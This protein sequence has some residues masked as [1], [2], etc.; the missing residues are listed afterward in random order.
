MPVI[1][2]GINIKN[3]A[4]KFY[5]RSQGL[6][7][8]FDRE[9]RTKCK[10]RWQYGIPKRSSN[11]IPDRSFFLQ[12]RYLYI[13]HRY[14]WQEMKKKFWFVPNLEFI[15]EEPELNRLENNVD[16]N[17]IFKIEQLLADCSKILAEKDS[18]KNSEFPV[19]TFSERIPLIS[20]NDH[21][22]HIRKEK[23]VRV[24]KNKHLRKKIKKIRAF[25]KH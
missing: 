14:Q 24:L 11:V 16:D 9:K 17:G 6:E 1:P 10:H 4:Q 20:T 19:M 23:K 15:S 18:Y 22:V 7:L 5:S 13:Q 21:A 25:C 12:Y 3:P 2:F 8:Q